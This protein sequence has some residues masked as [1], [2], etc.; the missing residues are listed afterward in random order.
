MRVHIGFIS[1]LDTHTHIPHTDPERD[2]VHDCACEMCTIDETKGCLAPI[3]DC[4]RIFTTSPPT[5]LT[6]DTDLNNIRPQQPTYDR[7]EYKTVYTDGSGQNI[8]TEEARAGSGVFFGDDDP[9]NLAL[10][11]PSSI[12]QTNNTAEAL[13]VLAEITINAITKSALNIEDSN[14]AETQNRKLIE[15]WYSRQRGGRSPSGHWSERTPN[16]RNRRNSRSN[17]RP[18]APSAGYEVEIGHP[19]Q[20]L[21]GTASV[22]LT[23][24]SGPHY[25]REISQTRKLPNSSGA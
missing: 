13:A 9:M 17:H 14:W 16:R 5:S 11:V 24:R 3:F 22:L 2:S 21:Q 15:L 1:Q 18:N 4:F 23:R 12:P 10:R 20:N 7:E 25:A 6:Q 8:G 19:R